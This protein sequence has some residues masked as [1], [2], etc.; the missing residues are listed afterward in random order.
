M[1]HVHVSHVRA[2]CRVA[3]VVRV[4]LIEICVH[5][6]FMRGQGRTM[7]LLRACMDGDRSRHTVELEMRERSVLSRRVPGRWS[8]ET[9]D[10]TRET[11]TEV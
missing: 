10:E 2:L 11:Q 8:R 3:V 9:I 1:A 7:L 4:V 6:G 5:T